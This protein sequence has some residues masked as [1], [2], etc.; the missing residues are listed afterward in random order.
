MIILIKNKVFEF[1]EETLFSFAKINKTFPPHTLKFNVR[2]KDWPF[3]SLSNQLSVVLN[4]GGNSDHSSSSCVKVDTDE[5][6]NVKWVVINI[7]GV[8]LY[9][10]LFILLFY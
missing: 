4:S 7:D 2:I 1:A 6:Q 10:L 5:R 8:S 3:L 9:L